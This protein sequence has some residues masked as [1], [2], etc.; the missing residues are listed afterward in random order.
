MSERTD[1]ALLAWGDLPTGGLPADEK[2][3]FLIAELADRLGVPEQPLTLGIVALARGEVGVALVAPK[4]PH[5]HLVLPPD[6]D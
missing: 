3:R 4:G 2:T 5:L 1:P 6:P